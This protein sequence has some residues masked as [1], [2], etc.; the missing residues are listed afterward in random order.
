[1]T[2]THRDLKWIKKTFIDNESFN[3]YKMFNTNN[4]EVRMQSIIFVA[5]RKPNNKAEVL[6]TKKWTLIEEQVIK[7]VIFIYPG[8]PIQQR[9]WYPEGPWTKKDTKYHDNLKF[10]IKIKINVVEIWKW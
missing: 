9:G 7:E 5:M 2:Q 1:M 8:W 10:K 3:N 4:Q 6:L